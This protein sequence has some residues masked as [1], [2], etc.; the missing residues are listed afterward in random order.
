MR[1]GVYVVRNGKLS[2]LVEASPGRGMSPVLLPDLEANQVRAAVL[3]VIQQMRVSRP[4]Q[5]GLPQ[6]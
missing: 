3:P 1:V 2:V 5:P 4:L 6:A